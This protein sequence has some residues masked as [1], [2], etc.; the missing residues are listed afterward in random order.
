MKTFF[1]ALLIVCSLFPI[2]NACGPGYSYYGYQVIDGAVWKPAWNDSFVVN[3]EE[4]EET[5]ETQSKKYAIATQNNLNEWQD[6][7]CHLATIEDIHFFIYES[8]VMEIEELQTAARSRK[9][10]LPM[11]LRN[12]TF[13]LALVERKCT[14][15]LEYLKFA[16]ECEPIVDR[17]RSNQGKKLYGDLLEKGKQQFFKTE[18]NFLRHR[19]A[20]QLVRLS[21]YYE[22]GKATLALNTELDRYLKPDNTI[23]QWWK[24][25]HIASAYKLANRYPESAVAY[26]KQFLHA[27][28]KRKSA[29]ESIYIRDDETFNGALKLASDNEEKAMIYALRAFPEGTHAA[30]DILAI[31]DL[32]P[33]HPMLKNLII[34]DLRYLEHQLL[35]AEINPNSALNKKKFDIP[36]AGAKPYAIELLQTVNAI[37]GAG[38]V[39]DPVFY[40]LA[41]AYLNI[42]IGDHYAARAILT[43]L[44]RDS[45]LDEAAQTQL[46]RFELTLD[47]LKMTAVNPEIE[48]KWISG[49][50]GDNLV[51]TDANFQR[52]LVDKIGSLYSNSKRIGPAKAFLYDWPLLKQVLTK[53]EVIE[54]I[55]LL[56]KDQAPPLLERRMKN[57]KGVVRINDLRNLLASH[58]LMEGQIAA[59]AAVFDK[60]PETEWENYGTWSPFV[61]RIPHCTHCP[62]PMSAERLN[63][64][65]LI[66]RMKKLDNEVRAN[67]SDNARQLYQLGIAYFNLSYHGSSWNA[68]DPYRTLILEVVDQHTAMGIHYDREDKATKS[69]EYI[70]LRRARDYLEKAR[71]AAGTDKELGAKATFAAAKCDFHAYIFAPDQLE[72]VE[73]ND[74]PNLTP[75]YR[76]YYQLLKDYYADTNFYEQVESECKYF[77]LY[78]Q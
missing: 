8:T 68:V 25:G 37:A 69:P 48:K 41:E 26:S 40:R 12:N 42:L 46:E 32:A 76:R 11:R 67:P 53:E 17:G 72:R 1:L 66:K 39:N 21:N 20:Y 24:L 51:E 57:K 35:G 71:L 50:S 15:T 5:T 31:H 9:L 38:K 73:R 59:A 56:E 47:I 6:R 13:A 36:N 7:I 55:D 29:L 2:G 16:K 28:G 64:G 10:V 27:P 62:P 30:D 70:D 3:K 44:K 49:V 58:Y 60:I 23:I 4:I 34:K 78:V 63:K 43:E 22:N 61:D 19:Y 18:S 65:Q 45:K 77:S 54:I 14:E 52:L 75:E 33:Q 74:V